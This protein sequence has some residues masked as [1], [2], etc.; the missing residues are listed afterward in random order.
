MAHRRYRPLFFQS[1]KQQKLNHTKGNLMEGSFIRM[2]T[3]SSVHSTPHRITHS[4]TIVLCSASAQKI[5]TC[6]K[7]IKDLFPSCARRSPNHSSAYALGMCYECVC[8][9]AFVSLDVPR[10]FVVCIVC[11][12]LHAISAGFC[13]VFYSISFWCRE[14]CVFFSS[15]L[16]F[17]CFW[18]NDFHVRCVDK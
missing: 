14:W 3:E 1:S 7:E 13:F 2:S 15:S 16:V 4:D 6:L 10:H 12:C 5:Q 11:P 9:C 8:V 18:G 17:V